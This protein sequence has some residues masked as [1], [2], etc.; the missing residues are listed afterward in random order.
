MTTTI[1]TTTT[2]PTIPL[3]PLLPYTHGHYRVGQKWVRSVSLE[4]LALRSVFPWLSSLP[5]MRCLLSRIGLL[6]RRCPTKAVTRFSLELTPQVWVRPL[7]PISP[8]PTHPH[9]HICPYP[10]FTRR[11]PR[12]G[13]DLFI[14]LDQR[15]S[16]LRHAVPCARPLH[17]C[18]STKLASAL[19]GAHPD[20]LDGTCLCAVDDAWTEGYKTAMHTWS[21]LNVGK[22]RIQ[23]GVSFTYGNGEE[24]VSATHKLKTFDLNIIVFLI[25]DNDLF[26]IAF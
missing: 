19:P 26:T 7:I 2:T 22:A 25:F 4:Q 9:P 13:N 11:F 14:W 18:S 21:S 15:C 1:T 17:A 8:I 24:V 12:D 16:H 23:N 6:R 10:R 20:D 3:P 5:L